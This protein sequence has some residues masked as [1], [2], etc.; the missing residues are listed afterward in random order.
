MHGRQNRTT[1][2]HGIGGLSGDLSA[3]CK[4]LEGK[5]KTCCSVLTSDALLSLRNGLALVVLVGSGRK[6]EILRLVERNLHRV[7]FPFLWHIDR[8]Q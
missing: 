7:P 6:K 5:I 2:A 1:P 8:S 4:M 3:N